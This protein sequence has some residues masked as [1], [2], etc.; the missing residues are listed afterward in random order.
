VAAAQQAAE[1]RGLAQALHRR[2]LLSRAMLAW[3]VR[4]A[5]AD[6]AGSFAD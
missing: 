5:L 3:R 4:C 2:T 6:G 1:G